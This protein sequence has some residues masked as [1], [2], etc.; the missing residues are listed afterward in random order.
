MLPGLSYGGM[1][2]MLSRGKVA[3]AD[4]GCIGVWGPLILLDTIQGLVWWRQPVGA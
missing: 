1:T 2:L 3:V 4:S